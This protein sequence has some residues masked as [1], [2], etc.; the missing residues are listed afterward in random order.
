MRT[1]WKFTRWL[2]SL[3][4]RRSCCPRRKTWTTWEFIHNSACQTSYES[5]ASKSSVGTWQSFSGSFQ[6]WGT[7][8]TLPSASCASARIAW[9]FQSTLLIE[10]K[11]IVYW[12]AS[13][14]CSPSEHSILMS[15]ASWSTRPI[16]MRAWKDL[17]TV[18]STSYF[19]RLKLSDS[20][21]KGSTRWL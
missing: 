15:L 5:W 17:M 8:T 19:E 18:N 13:A 20:A 12:T 14:F 4:S 2:W 9:A 11:R 16:W 1:L 6:R 21:V 7:T 10:S 3:K